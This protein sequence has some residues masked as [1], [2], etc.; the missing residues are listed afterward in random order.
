M[1]HLIAI[2]LTLFT[3]GVANAQS[4]SSGGKQYVFLHG[5]ITKLNIVDSTEVPAAG[6]PIEIWANGD[7]LTT[8]M[9]GQKGR[10]KYK[11]P[12]YSRYT[13]KYGS[14]PYVKKMIE[15][16]A[17]DFARKSQKRG[18]EMNIDIAL[19]EDRGYPGLDFLL[20]TPVAKA[21][22]SRR[23]NTVKWDGRHTEAVNDRIKTAIATFQK[24]NI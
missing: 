13:I 19:F 10:Y 5:V 21:E 23:M 1:K 12:F 7:L 2:A 11:L 14:V 15:I 17:S 9:S 20:Q 16:D 18:F 24:N 8:V 6:I 4:K 3:L 22:Y